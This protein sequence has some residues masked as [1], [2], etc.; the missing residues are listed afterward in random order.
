MSHDYAH[1]RNI[2]FN[3]VIDTLQSE[4]TVFC[5]DAVPSVVMDMQVDVISSQ[6]FQVSWQ[7]PLSPNGVIL[8]YTVQVFNM[9]DVSHSESV[10]VAENQSQVLFSGS[11]TISVGMYVCLLK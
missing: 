7:P 3:T 11:N 9:I 8:G 6:E 10:L 2:I 4:T 5:L 1:K